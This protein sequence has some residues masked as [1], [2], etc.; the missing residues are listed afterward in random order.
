MKA[1][2]F[3]FLIFLSGCMHASSGEI[4]PMTCQNLPPSGVG[5]TIA[6][7]G[8]VGPTTKDALHVDLEGFGAD[9][10]SASLIFISPQG[11]KGQSVPLYFQG[12]AII[13]GHKVSSGSVLSFEAVVPACL[14]QPWLFLDGIKPKLN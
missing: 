4:I 10:N 6:F 3:V 13:D 2:F 9:F 7:S 1:L 14:D 8:T 12:S 11:W 5:E